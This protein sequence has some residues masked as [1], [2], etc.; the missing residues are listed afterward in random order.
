MRGMHIRHD[1]WSSGI[2]EIRLETCSLY[3]NG[4]SNRFV[5]RKPALNF[6]PPFLGRLILLVRVVLL[7]AIT[8]SG[9]PDKLN[10]PAYYAKCVKSCKSCK[11]TLRIFSDVLRQFVG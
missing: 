9:P 6:E 8:A 11:G 5:Y 10:R 1:G 3:Q 2:L 7:C 4:K